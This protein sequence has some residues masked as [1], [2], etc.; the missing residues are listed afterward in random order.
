MLTSEY[1]PSKIEKKWLKVW[2]ENKVFKTYDDSDKPKYYALSMFPYPSG[3]L[4]K[5]GRASCRERVSA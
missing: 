2:E 5:I 1:Y 4:H 3:K